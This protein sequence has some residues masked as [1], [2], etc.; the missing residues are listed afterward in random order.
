M[1]VEIKN[2]A[3]YV[4]KAGRVVEKFVLPT[5]IHDFPDDVQVV[6]VDTEQD[7]GAITVY[8]A[9][10]SRAE[11]LAAL[12]EEYRPRLRQARDDYLDSLIG[13]DGAGLVLAKKQAFKAL[14]AEYQGKVAVLGGEA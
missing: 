6:E 12:A 14:R 5:G 8:V 7:L 2:G 10:P 9:P 4:V 11:Q 13:D 3:G 1:K